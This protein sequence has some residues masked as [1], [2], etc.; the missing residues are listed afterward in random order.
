MAKAKRTCGK[1]ARARRAQRFAA[2]ADKAFD[3]LMEFA[4]R[5]CRHRS[6]RELDE[7]VDELTKAVDAYIDLNYRMLAWCQRNNVPAGR[8]VCD[9]MNAGNPKPW[10]GRRGNGRADRQAAAHA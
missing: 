8:F 5:R 10:N 3:A 4:R 6:G 7:V 2:E 9:V 1:A